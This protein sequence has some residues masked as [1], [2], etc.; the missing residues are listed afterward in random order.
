MNKLT[1]SQLG[2]ARAN[3]AAFKASLATPARFSYSY[4]Q[5][6]QNLILRMHQRNWDRT[7]SGQALQADL[8]KHFPAPKRH[9]EMHGLL[10]QYC[11]SFN[12]LPHLL[13]NTR[14]AVQIEVTGNGQTHLVSGKVPR[15]DLCDDGSYAA[16]L[17]TNG[18]PDPSGDVRLP[19]VQIGVAR[20]L[21]VQTTDVVPGIYDFESASHTLIAF[22]PEQLDEV[23]AEFD[24]V[25]SALQ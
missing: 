9:K 23:L 12:A 18:S 20:V 6:L 24:G 3:P 14:L 8:E 21:G 13:A 16:V 19:F 4:M 1:F 7:Q 5:L 25:F 10:D 17:F 15:I 11:S 2:S 22:T